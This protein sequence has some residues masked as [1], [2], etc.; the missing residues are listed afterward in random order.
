MNIGKNISKLRGYTQTEV[1]QLRLRELPG[2]KAIAVRALRI[3]L[4]A[5][6]GFRDDKCPLRASALTFY[7]LLS[8]VPIVA[9]LFGIAKGFG[10][11]RMLETQLIEQFPEHQEVV[12][13]VVEFSYTFLESTRGGLVAGIG[14]LLLFWTVIRVLGNIEQSFNDIWHI[15]QPRTLVRKFTDYLAMMLIGPVNLIVSSSATVLISAQV[16][17]MGEKIGLSEIVGPVVSTVLVILP[18]L[19]IWV[20]FALVYIVMPN[21]KV[22]LVSGVVAAVIVGSVYQI[23]QLLFVEFQLGVASYN[24]VYGSFAALPLFLVWL[25]LSWLIVL[26]GAEISYAVQNV[27]SYEFGPL[28]KTLSPGRKRLLSLYVTHLSVRVFAEGKEPLTAPEIAAQFGIP[29]AIVRDVIADLLGAGLLS[30]TQTERQ[31]DAAYQPASDISRYTVAYVLEYLD[32]AG[33]DELPATP[34]DQLNTLTETLSGFESS[35]RQSPDN[36]LLSEI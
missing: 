4:L 30:Q 12:T 34:S 2:P 35:L 29:I 11:Q 8:I 36:R 22:R 31:K 16:S 24:A 10:F 25:Q 23:T 27:D 21:T 19:L 33:S 3:F 5:W 32:R 28:L 9:M 14:V 6:R 7:S 13:R 1:W 26:F 20:L 17:D 18:W 15:H